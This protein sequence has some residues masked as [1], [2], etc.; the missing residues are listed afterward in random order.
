MKK[1]LVAVMM[2]AVMT[3]AMAGCGNK[4]ADESKTDTAKDAG[5]SQEAEPTTAEAEPTEAADEKRCRRRGDYDSCCSS[6]KS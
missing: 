2:A 3:A 5:T 6:S 4:A 1:K